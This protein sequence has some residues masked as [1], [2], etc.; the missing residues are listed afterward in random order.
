M[1]NQDNQ[2][3]QE[4]KG[5]QGNQGHQGDQENQ[6]DQ[7]GDSTPRPKKGKG[8]RA[9]ED[10]DTNEDGNVARTLARRNAAIIFAQ[11]GVPTPTVPGPGF[12]TWS[13]SVLLFP[14]RIV[15]G[16]RR[17]TAQVFCLVLF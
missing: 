10:S 15:G 2:E 14:G 1:E 8:I 17:I 13:K 3:H 4:D 7:E 6:E 9:N 12:A 5:N 16:H 11:L